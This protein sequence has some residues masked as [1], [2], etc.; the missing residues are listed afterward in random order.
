ME[1]LYSQ[2][3]NVHLI[4]GK[5]LK[6]AAVNHLN[7]ENQCSQMV[8]CGGQGHHSHNCDYSGDGSVV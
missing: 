8:K 1:S 6:W 4:N 3:A 5:W 2:N 7:P